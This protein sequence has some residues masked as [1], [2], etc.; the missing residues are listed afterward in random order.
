MGGSIRRAERRKARIKTRTVG[1]NLVVRLA[2]EQDM[3]QL[4]AKA[5]LLLRENERLSQ[6]V[7][8][9]LRENLSLKGMSPEQLQQALSLIDAELS[10]AKSDE[11]GART[12]TE[13][14][15]SGQSG[16]GGEKKPR[17]GHGPT[18]QP[19]LPT[20]EAVHDVDEADKACGSCGGALEYFEGQDDETEEVEVIERR[21]FVKKNVRKKYRC[22]CG[23]IEMALMPERL[24]PGGRYSNDFAVEVAASKYIEHLP[25]DRQVKTMAAQG[26]VVE[27]QTLW[28]Q[29]SAL[30]KKLEPAWERLRAHALRGRVLGFDETS[31]PV[32]AKGND[33]NWTMWQLSTRQVVYFAVAEAADSAAG[34]EFLGDFAGIAI[35]DAATV[36]KSMAKSAAYRLAFCWAHGRRKFIKAEKNDPIRSRQFLEMAKELW[37]IE[38]QAPPGPAGD[39]LRLQLRQ[40]KSRPVVEQIRSW[41]V[42]QRFLPKSDIGIAIKYMA[43]H[44]EGLEVFLEDAEVPLDNNRTE[45]GFRGPALGRNNFYGSHSRRGTEVAA[46]IYSLVESAKLVGVEPKGYLKTALA[47]ALAGVVIPLPHEL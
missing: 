36:H 16:N 22:K 43:A 44:F 34:K 24:V 39:A 13:R 32:L 12:S 27:S 42:G 8:T 35:G 9:L 17:T 4:R 7:V 21:F 11:P 31:W 26:L 46:V 29:V 38:A 30:A 5:Q 6:K 37:V 41:L 47:A 33:K 25:F 10:R 1:D 40:E 45:R 15:P 2:D 23:C 3:D 20:I 14:R 19:N 28:D 18:P